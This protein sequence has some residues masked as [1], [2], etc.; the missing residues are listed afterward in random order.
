MPQSDRLY[1]ERKHRE[2]VEAEQEEEEGEVGSMEQCIA[3]VSHSQAQGFMGWFPAVS[4]QA[5]SAAL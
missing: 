4:L 5:D 1:R 2:E 3:K